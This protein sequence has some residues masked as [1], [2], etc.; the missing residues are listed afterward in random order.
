LGS[1]F[2][3]HVAGAHFLQA[4]AH[5]LKGELG[6]VAFATYVAQVEMAEV[7][8]HNLFGDVGGGFIREVTV[9][10]KDALFKAPGPVRAILQQF[11]IVIGFENQ[12]IS[13]TN[14]FDRQ[15]GG[16]AEVGE[17]TDVSM[18][19]FEQ[20]PDR[21]LRVVGNAESFDRQIFQVKRGARLE[22]AAI[23]LSPLLIFDRFARWPI[24]VNRNTKLFDQLRQALHVIGMLVS[25]EDGGKVLRRP[26]DGGQA[27]ADLPQAKARIDENSRLRSLQI[28]AVTRGT[29]SQNR[30]TNRHGKR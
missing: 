26:S 23:Q 12:H 15:P 3:A 11:D 17:E 6:A 19:G 16:V 1:Q 18:N 9:A 5:Y 30:Q 7:P 14:S 22:Q 2:E 27:F 28:G 4:L 25:D 8:G 10:A 20:K 24:A 29:A 13:A 21:I